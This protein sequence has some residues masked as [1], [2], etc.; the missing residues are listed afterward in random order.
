MEVVL[1]SNLI[2]IRTRFDDLKSAWMA[3]FLET[4]AH[5][6]LFLPKALLIS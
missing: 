3:S 4:H 5:D 6:V 1:Q 2:L